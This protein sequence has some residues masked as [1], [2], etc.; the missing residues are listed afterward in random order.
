MA[1]NTRHWKDYVFGG[2]DGICFLYDTRLKFLEKGED[3]GKGAPMSGAHHL[4]SLK[5]KN[6][7][8]VNRKKWDD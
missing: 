5:G 1:T 2:A 7:G 8:Q 4:Y 6:I 3:T